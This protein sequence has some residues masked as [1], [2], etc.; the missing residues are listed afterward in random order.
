MLTMQGIHFGYNEGRQVIIAGRKRC[1]SYIHVEKMHIKTLWWDAYSHQAKPCSQLVILNSTLL[2][3][4]AGIWLPAILSSVLTR[5]N[6]FAD[7]STGECS[8]YT[9]FHGREIMFHVSTLL[10]WTPNNRQQVCGAGRNFCCLAGCV[11][12]Y[13]FTFFKDMGH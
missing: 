2:L 13:T 9:Q 1:F 6:L 11:P 4:C 12:F 10:P 3:K 5:M 8:V 7:D